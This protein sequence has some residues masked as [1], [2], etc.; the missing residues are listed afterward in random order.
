[1]NKQALSK[2]ARDMRMTLS[3]HSPEILIG[4]G[5]TG[6]IATTV[7]AV[8]ATPKALY[9]IEEKKQELDVESLTP[10]ETV[11]TNWK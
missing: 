9:L 5:I 3:R 10:V 8:K 11:K 6:M 4:I 1:M 7:L 2:F